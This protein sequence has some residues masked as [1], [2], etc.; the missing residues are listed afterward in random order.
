VFRKTLAVA[1]MAIGMAPGFAVES[2]YLDT[3]PVTYPGEYLAPADFYFQVPPPG[4]SLR[5]ALSLAPSTVYD[6]GILNPPTAAKTT[7]S[8]VTYLNTGSDAD[9]EMEDEDADD[10]SERLRVLI[11]AGLDH[12]SDV[13]LAVMRERLA[14]ADDIELVDE[15][16][17]YDVMVEVETMRLAASGT[18]F[19]VIN[20]YKFVGNES[21]IFYNNF[22]YLGELR[23]L[24]GSESYADKLESA[25]LDEAEDAADAAN[26]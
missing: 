8:S 13:P 12:A 18:V 1:I 15:N 19:L 5:T 11:K 14:L 7:A 10:R 25:L 17:A 26:Y 24:A 23:L 2:M 3:V 4:V 16:S 21:L 6:F 22:G 9:D 20:A